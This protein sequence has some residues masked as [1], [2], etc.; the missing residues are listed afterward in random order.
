[1]TGETCR[2]DPGQLTPF[3]YDGR[4]AARVSAQSL[5]HEPDFVWLQFLEQS[6][7]AIAVDRVAA[8]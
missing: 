8:A 4:G 1:M 3:R 7:A 2:R 5:P 6:V